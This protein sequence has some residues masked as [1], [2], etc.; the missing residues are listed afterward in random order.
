MLVCGWS[1]QIN[2]SKKCTL[3][4]VFF[5]RNSEFPITT[6]S[7]FVDTVQQVSI[8]IFYAIFLLYYHLV[9]KKQTYILIKAQNNAMKIAGEQQLLQKKILWIVS[10]LLH[11]HTDVW[12]LN[13][14]V[15]VVCNENKPLW[16]IKAVDLVWANSDINASE[17][18]GH[19]NMHVSLISFLGVPSI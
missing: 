16:C 17:D 12:L 1:C 9:K 14:D 4:D 11:L 15:F 2:Q 13:Q 19:C 10:Y 6:S 5:Q 8:R 18:K 7:A 3:D